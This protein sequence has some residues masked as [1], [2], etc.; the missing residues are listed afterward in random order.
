MATYIID[1]EIMYAIEVGVCPI[2]EDT[3]K[4]LEDLGGPE[5]VD[6]DFYY[7]N[8]LLPYHATI[9]MNEG[10]FYDNEIFSLEVKDENENVIYRTT[11]PKSIIRY[12]YYNEETKEVIEAP[13]WKFKGFE[14]GHY[15]VFNDDLKSCALYGEFEADEFD[16]SKLSFHPSE[17]FDTIFCK[18]DVFL[19]EVRYDNQKLD[20]EVE[21]TDSFGVDIT[22]RESKDGHFNDFR[23][24]KTSWMMVR[25]SDN[26]TSYLL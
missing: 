8:D 16:P 17:F 22:L 2:D 9:V 12:P 1:M 19:Q 25:H 3:K 24:G 4:E 14:D 13:N 5:E 7:D 11:D 18:N 23:R 6:A 20:I 15:L 21:Y 10:V 26:S